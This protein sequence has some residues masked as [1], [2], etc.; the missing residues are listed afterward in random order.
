MLE[1]KHRCFGMYC[2]SVSVFSGHLFCVCDLPAEQ[3]REQ[4]LDSLQKPIK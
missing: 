1:R 3:A 2:V 4:D